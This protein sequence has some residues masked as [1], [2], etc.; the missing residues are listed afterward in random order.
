MFVTH[1]QPMFFDTASVELVSCPDSGRAA[2]T[3][4]VQTGTCM[5]SWE[6]LLSAW[7]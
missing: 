7:S 6:T 3:G 4:P 5:T 2:V 1:Q